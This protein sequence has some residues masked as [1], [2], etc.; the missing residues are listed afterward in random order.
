MDEGEGC[1]YVCPFEGILFLLFFFSRPP[2]SP[3]GPP[4]RLPSLPSPGRG[5]LV[6]PIPPYHHP[7]P[8]FSHHHAIR[9]LVLPPINLVAF[10][11]L[12]GLV[13]PGEERRI[14]E[15][16]RGRRFITSQGF[17]FEYAPDKETVH[18]NTRRAPI[19]RGELYGNAPSLG[20]FGAD[21]A[22][23]Q[24]TRI[25]FFYAPFLAAPA[26]TQ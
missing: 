19:H 4:F 6:Q 23:H 11:F 2:P 16:K 3:F 15:G 20:R 1:V 25:T 24:H 7:H 10:L 12:A 18:P 21:R 26:S 9:L 22:K 13:Y 14:G 17:E 5:F 8:S